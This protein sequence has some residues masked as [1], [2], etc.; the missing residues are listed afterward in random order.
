[1]LK[2]DFYEVVIRYRTAEVPFIFYRKTN[3]IFKVKSLKY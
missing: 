2:Y 1:M 3:E